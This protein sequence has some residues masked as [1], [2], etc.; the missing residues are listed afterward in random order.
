MHIH[1]PPPAVEAANVLLPRARQRR[2]LGIGSKQLL[3]ISFRERSQVHVRLDR[4]A[5]PDDPQ[6][7]PR[8]VFHKVDDHV[9]RHGRSPLLFEVDERQG[10]ELHDGDDHS[11]RHIGEG[12]GGVCGR[13]RGGPRC[14]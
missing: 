2:G 1:A 6:K 12:L 9:E 13:D 5:L 8:G 4:H 10:R 14:L 3:G 11:V 7:Q